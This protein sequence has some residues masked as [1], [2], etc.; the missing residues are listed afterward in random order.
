MSFSRRGII[1][2]GLAIA[3]VGTVGITSTLNAG[4]ATIMT[5]TTVGTAS[6][7][8]TAAAKASRPEPPPG[9]P[10]GRATAKR[11]AT[12]AQAEGRPPVLI[13]RRGLKSS[14]PRT[15]RSLPKVTRAAA[16]IASAAP[17]P[18]AVAAGAAVAEE[19][20]ATYH[21]SR[22][23]HSGT[24]DGAYAYLAA[25]KPKLGSNDFHTLAEI[26]VQSADE[27]QVIEVGWNVNRNLYGDSEPH[28]FVFHW[29]NGQ[30]TC[31]NGCG[32]EQVHQRYVAGMTL[33]VNSSLKAFDIQST[34]DAW[35]I[36]Y[37]TEWIGYF[38]K[39]LW[40]G[41][42]NEANVVQW[43]GEVAGAVSAEPCT[44]M[45]NGLAATNS[46]AA[47]FS[48]VGLYAQAP[49]GFNVVKAE[50]SALYSIKAWDISKPVDG[51]KN[52]AIIRFGGPGSRSC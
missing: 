35:W 34:G 6:A 12:A 38:P 29:V 18:A 16:G 51:D 21:Y 37:D 8:G 2:A 10:G 45:G 5:T 11:P 50:A 47:K 15:R 52:R 41:S 19:S 33:P 28:L 3:V 1:A 31:Y 24:N 7:A 43:Y 22:V 44:E 40:G 39:S 27:R 46:K 25:A 20:R 13:P 26:A 32:Y 30:P 23:A 42:F 48:D 36:G 17:Q 9:L 14:P 4:A 49:T